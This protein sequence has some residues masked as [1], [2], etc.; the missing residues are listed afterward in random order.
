MHNQNQNRHYHG[1]CELAKALSY[2]IFWNIRFFLDSMISL[3]TNYLPLNFP[4][5]YLPSQNRNSNVIRK[6]FFFENFGKS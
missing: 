2:L 5:L 3:I 1:R 4:K 6:I